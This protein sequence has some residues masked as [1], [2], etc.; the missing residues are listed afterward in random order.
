MNRLTGRQEQ[1][2]ALLRDHL[3]E[4]GYPPSLRTIGARLGIRSTNG[5]N[6]HLYAL[7]RKGFIRRNG[8]PGCGIALVEA[9]TS[10]QHREGP[11]MWAHREARRHLNALA[12]IPM[13][14]SALEL[15]TALRTQLL[16]ATDAGRL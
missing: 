14:P 9:E 7:E 8:G 15:L 5:V 11:A 16:D 4:H 6:D 2:L 10:G 13:T 12:K 1:V 3:H